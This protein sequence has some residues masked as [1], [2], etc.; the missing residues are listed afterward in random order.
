MHAQPI[1]RQ[2]V[3]NIRISEVILLPSP[4]SLHSSIP[5]TD[6]H[7]RGHGG[8]KEQVASASPC[9]SLASHVALPLPVGVR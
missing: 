7:P 8:G 6:V 4:P 2:Q 5:S 3:V 1:L 9:S